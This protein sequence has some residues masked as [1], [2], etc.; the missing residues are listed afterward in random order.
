[1]A[2]LVATGA[3][4]LAG[5]HMNPLSGTEA[6][7]LRADLIAAIG[8]DPGWLRTATE[9]VVEDPL[10]LP[11]RTDVLR[12][13]EVFRRHLRPGQLVDFTPPVR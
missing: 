7:R 3:Y 1:M 6:E 4:I 10:G 8:M 2:T 5:F 12:V 13:L 9:L 11:D